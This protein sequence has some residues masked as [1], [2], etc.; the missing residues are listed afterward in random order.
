MADVEAVPTAAAE[1][2]SD[3]AV[4]EKRGDRGNFSGR[5]HGEYSFIHSDTSADSI[6]G[7]S[8]GRKPVDRRPENARKSN[9]KFDQQPESSDPVEIR[10]QVEF[11]FSDANL[12]YDDFMRKLVGG[13][14]NNS[15]PIATIHSFKR[16]RHFQPFTAVVSALKESSTLN[17]VGD[18]ED[19]LQRKVA[20]VPPEADDEFNDPSMH[21]SVYIKGFGSTE[22]PTTQ[23]DIEN[24]FA[25]YGPIN[26]VRM[27]RK[28][29]KKDFKGSVFVE[30][31]SDDLQKAF[32]ALESKPEWNGKT[33]QVMTKEDYCK[34][35]LDD[36]KSGKIPADKAHYYK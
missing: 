31:Q 1:K 32:L 11:Y 10:K 34:S 35:K 19:H 24:F 14:D 17:V 21:R 6:T 12:A 33:L 28:L 25:P 23:Q 13:S 20:F 15:V 3:E 9:G 30:F 29:P 22:T 4:S 26:M 16:M 2:R 27:R 36:V 7:K 18:E 8:N 5:R